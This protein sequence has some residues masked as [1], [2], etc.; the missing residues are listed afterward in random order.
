MTTPTTAPATAP[1]VGITDDAACFELHRDVDINGI[2]GTG[3][4]ADGV[5]FAEPADVVFPDGKRLSLPAGWCRITWRGDHEST[6]LWPSVAS[7][8]AVH[9][10]GG[11]T[12]IVWT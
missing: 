10:H 9:G 2:S 5:R 8:I 12:R 3:H 1:T 11:N 6:V 7:A 4:I